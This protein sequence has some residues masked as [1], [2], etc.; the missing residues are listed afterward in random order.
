MEPN[1][2]NQP[3]TTA[4]QHSDEIIRGLIDILAV[5]Q[6][7]RDRGTMNRTC[8]EWKL[9]VTLFYAC[10]LLVDD[11]TTRLNTDT[12]KAIHQAADLLK[13]V[14][15]R[16]IYKIGKDELILNYYGN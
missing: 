14:K 7:M 1:Q 13:K 16:G 2:T 15:E 11:D 4:A 6:A 10:R 8:D 5:I 12:D 3:T 9:L